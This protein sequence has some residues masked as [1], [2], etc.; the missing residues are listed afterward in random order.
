MTHPSSVLPLPSNATEWHLLWV[1]SRAEKSVR[2]N[3]IREGFEAFVPTRFEI[4]TWR[5]GERRKVE[6]VLIPSIVFIRMAQQDRRIVEDCP[7][8]CSIMRDPARKKESVNSWDALARI[9]NDEMLLF[10]Q[11]LG[12]EDTDVQFASADFSVGE[13]VRIKDFGEKHGK[14][15]IVRIFGDTKT[16]VGLRVSFLG[17]DYM[18][19]PLSRIVKCEEK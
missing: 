10:Q 12:Q 13:Y 11:M 6:K 18:Q 5:R 7:G 2:D 17:C 14:A 15:Q 9:T 16:Y 8:V 3:L 4:H 1:N 19:M